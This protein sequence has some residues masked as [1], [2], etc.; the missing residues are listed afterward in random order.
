MIYKVCYYT[1]QCSTAWFG[2]VGNGVGHLKEVA[3]RRARL[4]LG[5]V[6]VSGFNSPVYEIYRGLTN[7]QCQLGLAI[8]P[9]VGAMNVQKNCDA[10]WLGSK[11]R[12]DA[13]L[14]AG[15]N[16]CKICHM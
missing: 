3:L 12:H 1:A 10:L 16:P 11:G 15:V 6:T 5:W 7:R 13:R 14:V 2:V 9:W 8:P 4:V